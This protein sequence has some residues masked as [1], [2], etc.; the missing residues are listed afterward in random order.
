[1][2]EK[3]LVIFADDNT[4]L[5]NSPYTYTVTAYLEEYPQVRSDPVSGTIT[6]NSPCSNGV[7]TINFGANPTEY[8]YQYSY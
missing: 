4:L 1:M 3:K 7:P 5:P 8:T 6:L 2:S